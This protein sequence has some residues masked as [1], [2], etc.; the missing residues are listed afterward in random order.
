MNTIDTTIANVRAII[1][2]SVTE[3]A[4]LANVPTLVV[5]DTVPMLDDSLRTLTEAD[6]VDA[7]VT[8]TTHQMK[9]H[10]AW[11][12]LAAG[13]SDLE[14]ADGSVHRHTLRESVEAIVLDA[15]D[16]GVIVIRRMA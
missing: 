14:M 3:Y 7:I 15:I 9:A 8:R 10:E 2:A 4:M 6:V 16:R 1:I 13:L 11:I 12:V 5:G